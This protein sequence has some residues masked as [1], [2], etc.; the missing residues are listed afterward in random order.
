[1]T[2]RNKVG[3]F[4]DE[5]SVCRKCEGTSTGL[6]SP[7]QIV[8][9]EADGV[10]ATK[11]LRVPQVTWSSPFTNRLLF[12]AGFGVSYY[13]WGN[14]EREGNPTRDLVRVQEQC[15]GGCANNGGI[16]SLVYRSQDWNDNYTGAY[17]W[18]ASAAYVTGA[19]S[20]KLGYQGTY[21]Y[22]ERTSF[23]NN[24]Q[25]MYRVNNGVPNQ[26]TMAVPFT[27]S[28]RAAIAAF[29]AQEQWTLGRLTLQGALRFDR[30]RGWF[31]PQ[32]V[33][34]TRFMPNPVSFPKT[35]GVDSYKDITPRLGVAYDVFGNGRTAAKFTLG[36]YLEGAST[37]NPVA[38]YNTNPTLRMPNTNPPFG[39]QGVQRT[40]TDANGNFQPDCD[41]QNPLSQDL[42]GTGGDFC[43]QISNL[44][45]GTDTL[46]NSFA[47]DV[48]N[49]WGV[50]SNDWGLSA[51]VQQQLMERASIEIAYHRRWFSGFTLNDNLFTT[52]SNY[53][54]YGI[55]APS[56][57]RLPD[58]GGYRIENLFDI[59]P[60]L[61][62][63]I[64]N[65][66]AL[67]RNYGEWYQYFNGLDITLNV[68]TRGGLTFQGG[69]STGQNVADNCDVRAQPAGAERRNR[70]R[71]RGLHRQ[72]DEPVLSRRLRCVD[73]V[74]S[75][76][77]LHHSAHRCS[78]ERRDA[79]QAWGDAVGELRRASIRHRPGARS[80]TRRQ[81][82]ERD[83]QSARAGN[84]LR[85]SDQPARF[86]R[87][88]AVSIRGQA[89]D[90]RPRPVQRVELE[91]DPDLQQ[92]VRAGRH[93]APTARDP[94]TK[95]VP[96]QRRVHL[97]MMPPGVISI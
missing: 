97:L 30:A 47:P 87:G 10:G 62:G 57:P 89:D 56:D 24:Q 76:R 25:L 49:G 33:G 21:F 35:E 70:R 37:G 79:E 86:S 82:A 2:P 88:Q 27:Q 60:S 12:D 91:C 17:T 55:T 50:R 74:P 68:R 64:N 72:H 1:M 18:R 48:L 83:R 52:S 32:Q 34:P 4:W 41:L 42:R 5:Q 63:R 85:R 67:A 28:A 77:D 9:P 66:T 14:F 69:T 84:P 7:A 43:G 16:P 51:S 22:D 96:H 39:P 73:T 71:A 38:F 11:P 36:K 15:A 75:A 80:P 53:T 19:H 29:Y 58:G 26:L 40:W 61:F 8:A 46:T 44:A 23:T 6:A 13:G 90:D 78:G 95:A 65:L 94:D 45:F 31:P 92:H 59:D 20:M 3:G 93:V 81:R 54:R